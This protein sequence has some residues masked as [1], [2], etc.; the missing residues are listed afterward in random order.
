MNQVIEQRIGEWLKRTMPRISVYTPDDIHMNE[1]YKNDAWKADV[2]GASVEVF[3]SLLKQIQEIG[4]P[5]QPALIFHLE[6]NN[7]QL[8]MEVPTNPLELERQLSCTPP[9]IYL[10]DWERTKHLLI[11]EWY[12]TPLPF[13][14]IN[15]PIGGIYAYYE[16]CRSEEDI[17]NEWEFVRNVSVM[18]YPERYRKE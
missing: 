7:N 11:C 4:T 10:L 9:S 3:L 16:E 18:Y 17:R 14:L 12:Q 2:I 1:L 6:S 5:L 15:P 8:T 13:D